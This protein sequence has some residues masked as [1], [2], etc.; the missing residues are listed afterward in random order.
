MSSAQPAGLPGSSSTDELSCVATLSLS[1]SPG[2]LLRSETPTHGFCW[3][4]TVC[5][6]LRNQAQGALGL[7]SPG[8]RGH[9][10][11]GRMV[12]TWTSPPCMVT[13]ARPH[14][15]DQV[16]KS[17]IIIAGDGRV[18]PND[19]VSIDSSREVDVLACRTGRGDPASGT[20]PSGSAGSC[21]ATALCP[22]P[23]QSL[24]WL[25]SRCPLP[26]PQGV[27]SCPS[28]LPPHLCFG[29]CHCQGHRGT[30]PFILTLMS[31]GSG[32][33]SPTPR[34]FPCCP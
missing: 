30:S 33:L 32:W 12:V 28:I 6:S 21:Q 18:G 22:M 14:L 17:L 31:E 5:L 2:P 13:R 25:G 7:Q 20:V 24:A 3:K 29:R 26:A 15:D 27:L 34:S 10:P 11:P 1:P 4:T 23:A 8:C 9:G 19:E 16:H